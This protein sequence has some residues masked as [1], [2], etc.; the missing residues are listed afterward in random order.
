LVA[1]RGQNAFVNAKIETKMVDILQ[2]E[3][4]E[5]EKQRKINTITVKNIENF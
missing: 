5:I 2:K 3:L 1:I 4:E